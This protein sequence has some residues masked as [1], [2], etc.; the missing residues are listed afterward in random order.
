[1]SPMIFQP[2]DCSSRSAAAVSSSGTIER[3]TP[4]VTQIW[5]SLASAFTI[6]DARCGDIPHAAPISRRLG[7]SP[8]SAK[9]RLMN[10]STARRRLDISGVNRTGW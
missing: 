7:P 2:C 6:R 4:G 1:M 3:A 8:C 9:N 5:P 10:A